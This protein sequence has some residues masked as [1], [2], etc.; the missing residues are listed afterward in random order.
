M[1][2]SAWLQTYPSAEEKRQASREKQ[3]TS[4]EKPETA[5]ASR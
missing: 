2:W 1:K 3:Q 5:S 4:E